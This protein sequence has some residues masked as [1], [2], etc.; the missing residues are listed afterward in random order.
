LV[1][2]VDRERISMGAPIRPQDIE[3]FSGIAKVPVQAITE[4]VLAGVRKLDE[5]KELEPML[6]EI[7]FDPTETPH[8]PTEIADILTT[9][10]DVKGKRCEAAFVLKGRSY[11]RVRS[12]DIG[13][14]ILRLR[15]LAVLDLMVLVAVGHI[16]DDAH[17]DF[18][19]VATDAECDFLIMDAV[20]CAR[21]LI[22]YERIC[23]EDGTPFGEDGLC[24]EG[25]RRAAGME[26]HF[27]LSG[28]PEYEIAALEDVS[29]AGARRLSARVVVNVAYSRDILRDVIRRATDEVAHDTYHRN[30]QV[31]KRWKGHPA[32]VVWLFVA[33]DSRDLRTHNWLVRTE[34]IDPALDPRMRPL[35]MEAVEYIGDIGV[36]W[37]EGYVEKRKYYREHTASKGE[38]LGKL[39]AL[40]ERALVAGEAVRQAFALYE[41]GTID[42][43]QLTAEVR[44]LSPEIG[45][46]LLGSG[47][48][49]LPPE[50]AHEYDA[51]A[52]TLIGW[53][54][55]I[56]LY[57]SERG[58]EMR[59]Q[60]ARAYLAR[61]TIKDFCSARQRLEL[62]RE[63]L[64]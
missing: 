47:D 35:R 58:Q 10:L 29:H 64:R 18:T 11:P 57:Y 16:Q 7:L 56:T 51:T 19:R 60:S 31:A 22:A 21:L 55:N 15:S 8:G 43:T 23:P 13:H 1:W 6:R 20:D 27:H 2:T 46:F 37:E 34:W 5:R 26:L 44:R 36:V 53:L 49:P 48:L 28:L 25:H 3:Q 32:Q 50:D 30:E 63:K 12:R 9:K 59:S 45:D 54:H 41:G 4:A 52:Q 14:Q 17:R 38:F 24:R 42:E 33:A 39:D 62:E 61:E 40:V